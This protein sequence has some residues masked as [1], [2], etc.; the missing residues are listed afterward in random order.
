MRHIEGFSLIEL[1]VVIAIIAVLATV[2]VP[3]YKSYVIK[4]KTS[5]ILAAVEN[6]SQSAIE[7]S[8]DN[9]VF[10][11][12]YQLGLSSTTDSRLVDDPSE[13]LPASYFEG[14]NTDI[15]IG[16]DSANSTPCG[17]IGSVGIQVNPYALG[18]AEPAV[19]GSG[20]S[21][22]VFYSQIYNVKGVISKNNFYYTYLYN[23]PSASKYVTGWPNYFIDDTGTQNQTNVD[24]MAYISANAECQ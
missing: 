3:A 21:F 12:A 16:D 8:Q 20:A 9:G 5:K 1:M 15:G 2:A 19:H 11:N 18:I 23:E 7:Y 22:M 17:A 13:F 24:A 6:L 10:P 4:A 14:P